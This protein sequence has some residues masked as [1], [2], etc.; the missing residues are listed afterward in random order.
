MKFACLAL[1]L[2]AGC[3]FVDPV[4][5]TMLRRVDPMTVHPENY[6]LTLN[7]PKGLSIAED[8][9]RLVVTVYAETGDLIEE[10]TLRR[11]QSGSASHLSIDPADYAR[12]T[13]LQEAARA[14]KAENPNGRNGALGLNMRPC[15][16]GEG[17]EPDARLSV[18]ISLS[19]DAE[20]LP[21]LPSIPVKTYLKQIEKA[22]GQPVGACEMHQRH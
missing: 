3:A 5:A 11:D 20:P 15:L 12:F 2:A 21:L 16:I 9:A 17:P 7:M 10:F 1:F 19:K 22:A 6:V 18:D 4:T 14:R 13:Q 8:S